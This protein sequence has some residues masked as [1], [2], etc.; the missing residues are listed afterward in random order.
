MD[1]KDLKSIVHTQIYREIEK[2]YI[3]K[4]TA[5]KYNKIDRTLPYEEQGRQHH[6]NCLAYEAI[7]KI[8]EAI[9]KEIEEKFKKQIDW[10]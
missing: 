5:L 7:I 3:D 6:V 2:K 10:E 4:A 1:K 8:V 9:R